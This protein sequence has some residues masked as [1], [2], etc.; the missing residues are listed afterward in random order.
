MRKAKKNTNKGAV[1]CSARQRGKSGKTRTAFK[2]CAAHTQ[3]RERCMRRRHRV[4]TCHTLRVAN[5][6]P[7][8]D[9]RHNSRQRLHRTGTGNPP[10]ARA[11]ASSAREGDAQTGHTYG[12]VKHGGD[13][14][15]DGGAGDAGRHCRHTHGGG[16]GTHGDEEGRQ[17]RAL[18][19]TWR[20]HPGQGWE[21]GGCGGAQ[22]RFDAD[23]GAVGLGTVWRRQGDTCLTHPHHGDVTKHHKPASLAQAAQRAARAWGRHTA[24][25]EPHGAALM[26]TAAA[27]SLQLV[28]G[29]GAR[30]GGH[31][32]GADGPETVAVRGGQ[33]VWGERREETTRRAHLA[34]WGVPTGRQTWFRLCTKHENARKTGESSDKRPRK[35][36][37]SAAAPQTGAAGRATKH[38]G[39][40]RPNWFFGGIFPAVFQCARVE[41]A[42]R[43]GLV[44]EFPPTV[45]WVAHKQTQRRVAA[46]A[47]SRVGSSSVSKQ[48]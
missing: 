25:H 15:S 4:K 48:G 22:R 1:Q 16:D 2:R 27:Q 14:E 34:R 41:G 38:S 13:D 45:Q 18:G 10:R 21:M 9:S 26:D 33:R 40:R 6:I 44:A 32:R 7:A 17:R 20:G 23:F 37:K 42:E 46:P 35:Q 47:P 43:F 5:T 28:T 3:A 24:P 31:T 19:S 29:G 11:R 12:E 8:A 39:V 36:P 30:T